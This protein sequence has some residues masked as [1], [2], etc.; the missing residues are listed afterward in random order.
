MRVA[1]M[2]CFSCPALSRCVASAPVMRCCSPSRTACHIWKKSPARD[3][4]TRFFDRAGPITMHLPDRLAQFDTVEQQFREKRCGAMPRLQLLAIRRR[5]VTVCLM[6][7]EAADYIPERCVCCNFHVIWASK[8]SWQQGRNASL[9]S[10]SGGATAGR[11][12]AHAAPTAAQAASTSSAVHCYPLSG[13]LQY[14]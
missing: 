10:S 6:A 12:F 7:T 3:L 8:S 2:A 4:P 9:P 14:F 5:G 11:A 13:A 1:Q